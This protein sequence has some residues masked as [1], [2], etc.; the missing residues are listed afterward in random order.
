MLDMTKRILNTFSSLIA[1]VLFA[2]NILAQGA[3]VNVNAGYG[4]GMATQNLEIFDFY[5]T[6]TDGTIE[7]LEQVN[8]SLGKGLNFGGAFGYMFTKNIGVELGV[9]YL[10]GGKST[11]A[12][13]FPFG[14]AEF[15][16]S[17]NML[18]FTPS[19]VISSGLD[20]IVNPYAKLGLIVGTGSVLYEYEYRDVD[21]DIEKWKLN[22]GIAF[23]LNA[24]LG[25]QFKLSDK[26][27]F[28]S[29]LNMVS[30]SYAPT[31]GEFIESSYNGTDQLSGLTT[32]E[33]EMEFVDEFTYDYSNRPPDS[34]PSK[35][36][37]QNLPFGSVGL[38]IGWVFKF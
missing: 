35:S 34:E 36:L 15:S 6:K 22:G 14:R 21:V 2:N 28:Y 1:I 7:T 26:M 5:N 25:A 30:M 19:I 10:L 4:I 24:G 17:A 9:S 38:S 12:L 33:K 11:A 3:Y 23:G 29:E 16:L 31:K 8:V 18:R 32:R 27:S 20:G 37:K 13:Q